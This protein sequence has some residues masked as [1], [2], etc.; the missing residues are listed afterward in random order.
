M[1]ARG[2]TLVEVLV[3]MVIFAIIGIASFQVLD[4]MVST[5]EQSEKGTAQLERLQYLMLVLDRDFQQM[6]AKPVRLSSGE[7][8]QNYVS[9]DSAMVESDSGGVAFVRSGYQNPGAILPRGELQPVIYRV[10]DK[11]LQ[12]VSFPYVND[13]SREPNVRQLID[14]VKSLR[15]R[16]YVRAGD[17][18]ENLGVSSGW[19]N[20]WN[21]PEKL[22]AAVEMVLEL[23]DYGEIRRVW[24]VAGGVANATEQSE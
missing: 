3:T 10:R 15:F 12:R 18:N 19:R 13:R 16:F 5:K 1:K 20:D 7:L 23:E 11:V 21:L 4:Q 2:F 14:G 17:S 6:V 9:N 8:A 24:L 22:P